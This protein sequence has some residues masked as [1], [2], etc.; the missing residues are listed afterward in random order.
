M[1]KSQLKTVPTDE[2]VQTFIAGL[3]DPRKR[4]DS[5]SLIDL[6]G[7]I[8]GEPPVLWNGG[9]IGFGSYRYRYDSGREGTFM[10]TGFAPR[11]RELSIYIMS[12]FSDLASALARL[13]KARTGRSCLY[14]KRLAD[15]DITV[16]EA[17]IEHSVAQMARRYP[18]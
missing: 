6:I 7:R 18:D 4:A 13:G 16:L 5:Q 9:I 14:V 2:D 3:D 1:A 11:K 17:M 12:G 8:T 10:R 15:I